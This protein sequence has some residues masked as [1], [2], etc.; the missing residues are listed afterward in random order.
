MKSKFLLFA[1]ISFAIY[2]LYAFDLSREK[3]TKETLSLIYESEL[4]WM[5]NEIF[6]R[7]GY[8]FSNK[9]YQDY[10]ESCSWYTPAKNNKSVVLS[11]IE[12]YNVGLLKQQAVKI[13]LAKR[14]I[15]EYL[16]KIKNKEIVLDDFYG[17]GMIDLIK[18]DNIDFCGFRGIYSISYDNGYSRQSYSI[19]IDLDKGFFELSKLNYLSEKYPTNMRSKKGIDEGDAGQEYLEGEKPLLEHLF[20]FDS[21]WNFT[22]NGYKYS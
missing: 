20:Y 10:F 1:L 8:V 6:A 9:D 13:A 18:V 5:R 22:Y 12:N 14:K 15:K 19:L 16:N 11:D 7:K 17:V 3:L 2:P 4:D 21:N